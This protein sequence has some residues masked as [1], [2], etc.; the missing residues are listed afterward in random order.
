MDEQTPGCQTQSQPSDRIVGE[1][2]VVHAPAPGHVKHGQA[3]EAT[4]GAYEREG[5]R[6]ART[7][8][9]VALVEAALRGERWVPRL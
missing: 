2:G 8:A 5:A 4:V 9:A 3:I 7:V 6:L 1:C